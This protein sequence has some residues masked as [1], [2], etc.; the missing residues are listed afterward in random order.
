M[1]VLIGIGLALVWLLG[2]Q[3]ARA[4]QPAAACERAALA[5]AAETGVPADILGALTL[6]ETG[7][8]RDGV[9]QPWAWS[10]NSEG[11]GT[12]FDDP[13]RALAFAEDRVAQGRR[14]LDIGC[15]QLNYRWHGQHFGS[16]AEMFDPMQNARYAARFLGELHAETGDWRKA[17]GAFH[18]RSPGEAAKYLTRFDSLRAMLQQRGWAGMIGAEQTYNSFAGDGGGPISLIG[19]RRQRPEA[20]RLAAADEAPMLGV[21]VE[22]PVPDMSRGQAPQDI[23]LDGGAAGYGGPAPPGGGWPP[24][25]TAVGMADGM[26]G[27]PVPVDAL[28]AEA[29]DAGGALS[30]DAVPGMIPGDAAGSGP[31]EVGGWVVPVLPG[32]VRLAEATPDPRQQRR[33][34]RERVM[35]LGAPMGSSQTGGAGSLAVLGAARGS[36]LM[37]DR[38]AP[39]EGVMP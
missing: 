24:D 26:A 4:S 13:A 18:S 25:G 32:E 19:D 10:V 31:A 6:T 23:A 22:V 29:A 34:P 17:A 27:G 35:L 11:A 14:N 37:R 33:A 20:V 38:G 3:G 15:F 9:V 5:V 21:G 2:G 36:L 1:R 16:V 7:R 12:W 28:P 8:R 30:G 39:G